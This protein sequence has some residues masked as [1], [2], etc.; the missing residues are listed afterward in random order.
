MFY[1]DVGIVSEENTVCVISVELIIL[2]IIW[3]VILLFCT[4]PIYELW[5]LTAKKFRCV[6]Y[7]CQEL[8]CSHSL[9]L[10]LCVFWFLP[11]GLGRTRPISHACLWGPTCSRSPG[12][13][14]CYFRPWWRFCLCWIAERLNVSD[15]PPIVSSCLRFE[16]SLVVVDCLT[17]PSPCA[18]ALDP[19]EPDPDPLHHQSLHVPTLLYI[20]VSL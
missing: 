13:W 7:I 17:S 15:A 6:F 4:W 14:R 2:L 11:R 20:I 12:W 1:F 8:R 3:S 18:Q 16:I 10:V 9:A 5:N 19:S